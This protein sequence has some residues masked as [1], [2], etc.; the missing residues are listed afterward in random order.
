MAFDISGTRNDPRPRGLPPFAGG[1]LYYGWVQLFVLSLTE[2]V[3]WGII[4]YAFSV[5]IV[6]MG[7]DLGWTRVEMTGAFSCGTLISGLAGVPIGRWV[8]RHGARAVMTI[9]SIAASLLMVA[10]AN[11][12]SLPVFYLIW[13]GLGVTMAAVLYEPSFVVVTM[14]FRRDRARAL[15]IL[16]FFGGL[17]SVVFLPLT[18]WLVE[19]WGWREALLILAAILAM[20]TI[21][22]HGVFLRHRPADLG[23]EPDGR[24]T[25][26]IADAGQPASHGTGE[27]VGSTLHDAVRESAFWWMSLSFSLIW[28][29][30]IATLIHLIPY[31]QDQGFSATFAATAAGAIGLLKLP[32]RL[33][34]APLS[35]RFSQQVMALAIFLAHT[36]AIAV[37]AIADSTAMVL[38]FVVLFSAGNGALTLMRATLVANVFGLRAYGGISGAVAMMNQMAMALGPIAVSLLVAAWGTYTPVFWLL[39]AL[40][41]VSAAGILRVRD[42]PARK[43][44]VAAA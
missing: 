25:G 12:A 37:L 29:C 33:V 19:R 24:T 30:S 8:D 26:A 34:F 20:L 40:V 15:A 17:A 5:M 6:P 13:I 36:V 3:S 14:W 31:L 18:S 1:P 28:G 32:G 23:L 44:V 9:G 7:D 10:W 35:T 41:A 38:L 42:I 22:P 4:Y 11:V 27:P 2:L 21:A 43:K 39:S 16:T